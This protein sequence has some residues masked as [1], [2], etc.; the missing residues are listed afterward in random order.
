MNVWEEDRDLPT[1]SPAGVTKGDGGKCKVLGTGNIESVVSQAGRG[2][3][4]N[5][6]ASQTT[7]ELRTHAGGTLQP[8]V[9]VLQLNLV[10]PE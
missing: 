3:V 2:Q 9:A 5:S 4:S 8:V 1:W 7:Q 10:Y 6:T